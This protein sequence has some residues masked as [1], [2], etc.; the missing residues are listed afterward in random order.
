M[1]LIKYQDLSQKKWTEIYDESGGIYN[2]K[3]DFR[4]KTS[5]LRSD[6]CD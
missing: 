4:F 5:Q 6:L 2:T 1:F 3:K